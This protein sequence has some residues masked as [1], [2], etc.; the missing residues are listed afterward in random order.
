MVSSTLRPNE[1][2]TDYLMAKNYFRE[3]EVV[4]IIVW[5]E[6]CGC[7]IIFNGADTISRVVSKS[8]YMQYKHTKQL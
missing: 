4:I 1:L 7:K 5:H 8:K 3:M 6:T 2:M